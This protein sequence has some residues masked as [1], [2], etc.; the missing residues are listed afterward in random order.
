MSLFVEQE[1][2]EKGNWG[3]EGSEIDRDST[4]CNTIIN[5][6]YKFKIKI[7]KLFLHFLIV[8]KSAYY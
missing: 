1:E 5:I 4:T 6:K 3:V 2:V 7:P 8:L